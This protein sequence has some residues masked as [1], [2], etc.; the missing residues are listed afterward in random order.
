MG[1]EWDNIGSNFWLRELYKD[2]NT[3]CEVLAVSK[4]DTHNDLGLPYYNPN[5][6]GIP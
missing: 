6:L 5:R 2:K 1:E 3:Y 4:Y